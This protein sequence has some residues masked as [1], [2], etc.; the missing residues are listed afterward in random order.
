MMVDIAQLATIIPMMRLADLPFNHFTR[1]FIYNSLIR[2][3][4]VALYQGVTMLKSTLS[5][6][7]ADHL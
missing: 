1:L 7:Q 5:G 4:R 6:S 2:F 3:S